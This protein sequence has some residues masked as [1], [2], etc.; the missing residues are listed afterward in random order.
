MFGSQPTSF[1][2]T[3]LGGIADAGFKSLRSCARPDEGIEWT[4]PYW[5]GS[6]A[7]LHAKRSQH[8]I[9]SLSSEV[10]HLQRQ[11]K[12]DQIIGL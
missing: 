10:V 3:E 6:E 7:M 8:S 5:S 4:L 12:K 9:A 1:L 11:V 2:L